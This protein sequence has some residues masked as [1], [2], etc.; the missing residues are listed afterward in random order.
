MKINKNQYGQDSFKKMQYA[1]WQVVIEVGRT[2]YNYEIFAYF[3]QHSLEKEPHD[4]LIT[5]GSIVEKIKDDFKF[6]IYNLNSMISFMN[7]IGKNK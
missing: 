1:L 6:K 3:L 5:E 4:L 7:M 2:Y